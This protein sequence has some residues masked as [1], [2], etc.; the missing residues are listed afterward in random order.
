MINRI[1]Y[2]IWADGIRKMQMV[3]SSKKTNWK[4]ISN[5]LMSTAGF[6][7]VLFLS[8]LLPKKFLW[9]YLV[10]LQIDF[11]GSAYLSNVSFGATIS[12]VFFIMNYML[13]FRRARYQSF[14][15]NYKFYN[16]KLFIGYFVVSIWV[17]ILVMVGG[18]LAAKYF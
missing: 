16:G 13:I 10:Y 1:Y 3:N 14:I 8:V 15:D 6:V 7:N 2:A 11:S 4:F 9:D 5:V 17:P 18:M 12:C